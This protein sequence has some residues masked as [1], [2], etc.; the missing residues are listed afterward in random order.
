MACSYLDDS[1][2]TAIACVLPTFLSPLTCSGFA[3]ESDG[4]MNA[5]LHDRRR[6]NKRRSH[7]LSEQ[8]PLPRNASSG[9]RGALPQ[10]CLPTAQT[11]QVRRATCLL[12]TKS[13]ASLR[14]HTGPGVTREA[15]TGKDRRACPANHGGSGT[16]RVWCSRTN[17]RRRCACR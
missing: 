8:L 7:R 1:R 3:F 6:D 13:D 2:R 16:S 9:E 5:W 10:E 17:R 14:M 12:P 15:T 11:A 4:G